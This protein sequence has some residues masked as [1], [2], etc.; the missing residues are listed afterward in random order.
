VLN[1]LA[2]QRLL[3]GPGRNLVH[4]S[5]LRSQMAQ[6]QAEVKGQ[7]AQ[8]AQQEQAALQ[9]AAARWVWG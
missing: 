3:Q 5:S 6:L 9:Q 7:L 4:T 1:M 8:L 2:R